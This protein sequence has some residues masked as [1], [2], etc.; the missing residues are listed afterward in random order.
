MGHPYPAWV[1]LEPFVR[2]WPLADLKR[3]RFAV[4]IEGKA[5]VANL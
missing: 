5:D 4:A 3:G 2:L 1:G